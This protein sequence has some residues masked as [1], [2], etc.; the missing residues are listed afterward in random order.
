MC[1]LGKTMGL[2]TVLV[3]IGILTFSQQTEE[4]KQDPVPRNWHLLD[5]S[6]DGYRGISL[7]QAYEFVK[8]K[9]LK[10]K[11]VLVA[12]IDSGIDTLHEDLREI[13]WRNPKEIPGN[14]LDDDGN[15]YADD[16]YGWNFLGNKDGRNVSR[17]SYEKAR[18]YH[19]LKGKYENAD[20]TTL[21]GNAL[22]E[23]NMW[24]RSKPR[25]K[26][27]TV[28]SAADTHS[29]DIPDEIL[30]QLVML[31]FKGAI[32]DSLV[33]NPSRQAKFLKEKIIGVMGS[34]SLPAVGSDDQLQIAIDA[35]SGI[36][37]EKGNT[38]AAPK[39]PENYRGAITGD[40]E[41]D[42]NDKSYGNADVMAGTSFHGTHVSGIIGA[43]RNNGKG[44]DGIADNVRII[45]VR[46]VP[47]GDEHDKDIAL[48]IRY[49]VDNGAQ[50]INMSF[51]KGFS[52]QKK[53]VDEAV[54][55]ANK[56]GVLLVHA[57][58]N[59]SRKISPVDNFPNPVFQDGNK[60]ADNWITVGA[61]DNDASGSLTASFSNYGKTDV[62][63]FAP[64]VDIYS[65][66]PGDNKYEMASG[67]SMASPVVT[68][69]AAF[70][71]SYFPKLTPQQLK[72]CLEKSVQAPAHEVI[73]PGSAEKVPMS[74]LARN[75]GVIN[76]YEAAK[77]A[78]TL[79]GTK[80]PK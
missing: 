18:V 36:A 61:S 4:N 22:V 41:N 17:D 3:L 67:T 19:S 43:I 27:R 73:K 20:T 49:A 38:P 14:G 16:I 47:D 26:G 79:K 58:G 64:G 68:G 57:A 23:Y 30:E 77:I 39:A 5:K 62:D 60:I 51:G 53:W 71:K 2:T 12:V 11:P 48:A 46:A 8:S 37:G 24:K 28:S 70:L 33:N 31:M 6:R 76:V 29:L 42:I 50:I 45:F 1:K 69:A 44:I 65:T 63:V 54:Q 7:N 55:Y 25:E 15:G 10:S 21:S 78:S 32:P 56:K 35:L 34:G 52:P 59:D 9:N 72:Y 74:E 75:G 13:L 66:V 40:N 80:V